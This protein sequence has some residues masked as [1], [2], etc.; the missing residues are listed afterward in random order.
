[1]TPPGPGLA[2][3]SNLSSRHGSTS[4]T[5]P[6]SRATPSSGPATGRGPAVRAP[7][8]RSWQRRTAIDAQC[9]RPASGCAAV[10]GRS[11]AQREHHRSAAAR[12]NQLPQLRQPGRRRPSGSYKE[13]VRGMAE[14][15]L[16]SACRSPRQRV[17]LQRY[18]GGAIA[19]DSGDRRCGPARDISLLVRP[20]VHQPSTR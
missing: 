8:R 14:A 1:M 17:A 13:A 16:P 20:P 7:R 19:P 9:H 18:P 5:T 15:C 4:S 6:V 12:H 2:P 3:G 10:G 11:H